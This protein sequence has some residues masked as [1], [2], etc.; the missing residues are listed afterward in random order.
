MYK[1]EKPKSLDI[2]IKKTSKKNKNNES[3]ETKNS[4][5]IIERFKDKEH[6]SM[7]EAQFITGLNDQTMRK[8][9]DNG[10]I[11]GYRVQNPKNKRSLSNRM[12]LKKAVFDY[13][14]IEPSYIDEHNNSRYNY[15]Y[16]RAKTKEEAKL[17]ETLIKQKAPEFEN[18]NKI[19]DICNNLN[20]TKKGFQRLL[21]DCTKQKINMVAIAHSDI[22]GKIYHNLIIKIIDL[23]GGNVVNLNMDEFKEDESIL[24]SEILKMI[25]IVSNGSKKKMMENELNT[26]NSFI[27]SLQSNN[28]ISTEKTVSAEEDNEY[29]YYDSE[30]E[31]T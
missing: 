22:L 12:F 9:H 25:N 18:A 23:S 15:I 1:T 29:I 6:L 3:D 21:L 4:S 2:A 8:L 14:K 20:H 31:Q 17:Q 27:N 7:K 11:A 26:V 28:L 10:T 13:V 5:N 30:T 19:I 24:I 16:I